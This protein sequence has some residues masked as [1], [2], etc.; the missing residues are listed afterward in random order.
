MLNES[1]QGIIIFTLCVVGLFAAFCAFIVAIIYRYQKK[2]NTYFKELEALKVAHEIA[3]LQ[4]QL[5][6]Q[7]QTFQNI[8]REI[9]DNIGQKLTLAKLYLNTLTYI[10]L[11]NTTTQVNNSVAKISDAIN[12]LSDIS[13]S[14]SS[15]IIIGDGLLKGIEFEVSQLQKS[16]MY[17]IDFTIVG[18]PVYLESKKELILFRI[19][20]ESINNIIKHASASKININVQFTD[21]TMTLQIKDNGKGFKKTEK[22]NGMG[23]INIH[24]R[25][26]LLNGHFNVDSDE[27]GTTLIIEISIH[28]SN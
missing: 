10:N 4:A 13:R 5:E 19:F 9:H 21:E 18:E 8:S 20:Q 14:M 12:D 28:N 15:E 1:I 26:A 6:M 7:E 11:D 17:E 27:T 3:L 22:K 2:Q 23:F 16:G 24:D 25:T